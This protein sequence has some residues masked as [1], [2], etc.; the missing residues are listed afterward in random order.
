M[1]VVDIASADVPVAVAV[2][3]QCQWPAH[4]MASPRIL[5]LGIGSFL[6]IF[7]ALVWVALLVV[8]LLTKRRRCVASMTREMSRQKRPTLHGRGVA[9]RALQVSTPR[10]THYHLPHYRSRAARTSSARSFSSS[11][12]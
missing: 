9:F 2:A 4:T 7:F 3:C 10:V 5:G 6:I 8:G 12:S 11:S 1:R